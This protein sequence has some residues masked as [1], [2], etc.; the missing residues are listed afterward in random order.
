MMHTMDKTSG[1]PFWA[2]CALGLLVTY[3]TALAPTTSWGDAPE[4][5][6]AIHSHGVPH[7]PGYPWYVTLGIG[8][9]L[10]P[11][12]SL[13][14]RLNILSALVMTGGVISLG[15]AT[16]RLLRRLE[17]PLLV[18]RFCHA[19]MVGFVGIFGFVTQRTAVFWLGWLAVAILL[20]YEH[21]LV[22]PTDLRRVNQAFFVVN[23]WVS[24]LLLVATVVDCACPWPRP[25]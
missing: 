10:I 14:W 12:G 20:H 16:E 4:F 7:P 13:P 1:A 5:A 9:G 24:A 2:C 22:A 8:A 23:G 21:R 25:F 6:V 3:L 15:L 17:T 18:A 11:L 19:G